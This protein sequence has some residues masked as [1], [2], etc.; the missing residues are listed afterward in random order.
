MAA[1]IVSVTGD[2]LTLMAVP[3]FVL[4]STGSAG[5]AG[6]VA[7][8]TVLPAVAS[9]VWSGPI[10]D[11]MGRRRVSVA[12]DVI[13]G[14]A[15]LAVPFLLSI[16]ELRFWLLCVVMAVAG[17]FQA[18]GMTAR[19]VLLPVLAER[20]GLALG[21]A[22]GFYDGASRCAGMIGSAIGG[23]LI[24]VLGAAHVLILDGA[25]FALSALL[26]AY[27]TRGVPQAGPDRRPRA[28]GALRSYRRDLAE[29]YRYVLACPL[30]VGI[31]LVAL[32]AQGLDQGWSAVL[33][34]VDVR[35][36]LGGAAAL[37]LVEA[38]FSAGALI[39]ALAYGVLGGGFRRRTI[40]VTA[41]LIVGMPRFMVA[42]GTST[43]AP[44]AVM[45]AVEG[46]ACGTLNPIV[47]TVIYESVPDALRA[48]VLSA[49]TASG[50]M[51]T[52]LG[53]LAAGLLV[54]RI[55]V[56]TALEIVGVVYLLVTLC[57]MVFPAWRLMD[58]PVETGPE[59]RARDL[60]QGKNSA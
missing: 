21:R 18:P 23:V 54:D 12:A 14:A 56:V 26:V 5:R 42:A 2:S 35:E 59:N 43:V 44:L 41:F 22:A 4:Q 52:P 29:G 10:I 47:A 51:V 50:L 45:M 24:A 15:V 3:W 19:G 37:G 9:A 6:V 34:P 8:C 20:A 27:G 30:L 36:R 38:L 46:L 40:Y 60:P 31:C 33:L 1:N 11:R 58:R 16:G 57:P 32:A 7:S 28:T 17:L 49:T 53:A 39:G 48:R 55:G 13:C 25:T